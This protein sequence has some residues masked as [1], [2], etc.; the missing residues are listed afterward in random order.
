MKIQPQKFAGS[1][2]N[3]ESKF[4]LSS[5][6]C[7]SVNIHAIN[8]KTPPSIN[9]TR[10]ASNKP[11]IEG[12]YY[13]ASAAIPFY[14]EGVFCYCSLTKIGTAKIDVAQSIGMLST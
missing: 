11:K 13:V 12:D 1:R 10:E 3:K 4:W 6:S 14:R 9:G 5:N 7:N 8:M 2:E